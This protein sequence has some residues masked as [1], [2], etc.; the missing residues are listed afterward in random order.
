MGDVQRPLNWSGLGDGYP[1]VSIIVPVYN[2]A[3]TIVACIASLLAQDYPANRLEIIV[4]DNGSRDQ[5]V[6]LLQASVQSERIKLLSETDVLNAYGA[7]NTGAK[8]AIG[9][10]LAFTDADCFAQ[11]D[12]LMRLLEDCDDQSIGVFI[13]D[14][15]AYDPKTPLEKYYPN[16]KLSWRGKDVA[17]VPGMRAG[18]CAIRRT[19]FEELGGFNSRVNSGGDTEFAKRM[20]G[21]TSYTFKIAFDAIVF[22]KNYETLWLIFRRGLRFGTNMR[23]LRNDSILKRQYVSWTAHV[24]AIVVNLISLLTRLLAFPFVSIG[25]KYRG[26]IIADPVMFVVDPT[27]RSVELVGAFLG[28]TFRLRQFR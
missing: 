14:I 13:G 12:W 15:L 26:R 25:A 28:R 2:G 7:R 9:E 6:E 11:R 8:E 4:V 23:N 17:K 20:L 3:A 21:T 22:H 24:R 16:E 27:V 18:N 19:C 10:I 1:F 5:T